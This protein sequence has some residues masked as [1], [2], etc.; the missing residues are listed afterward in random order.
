MSEKYIDN[1]VSVIVPV[2]NAEEYLAETLDSILGQTYENIEILCIDDMSTDRSRDMLKEYAS[3]SSKVVPILL[4]KNGGVSNA[5]NIGIEKSR[6][7][8]IAFLD[9]DDVWLPEKIEKQINFMRENN[10]EFTFTSYQ[11]IDSD[12]NLLNTVV[13]AKKELSYNDLL[14]HN[15]ISCLT[16]VID[17]KYVDNIHMPNIHHEDYAAWLNIL[18]KGHKAYGLDEKLALYRKRQN[19]LSGN[20]LKAA[21]WTWNILRHEEKIGFFKSVF[22]FSYYAV[23]NVY[24]HFLSK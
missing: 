17:K 4:E 2:Y 5:R 15:A 12:S 21:G 9:S 14:K 3:K 24:K 19:S 8:F 13:K 11:F 23:I 22:C 7:R 16:V 20:K 10:Y 6:G 18:K 1:L